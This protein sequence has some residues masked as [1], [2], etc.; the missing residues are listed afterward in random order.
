MHFLQAVATS[1][2][3][4]LI[5]GFVSQRVHVLV[6]SQSKRLSSLLEIYIRYKSL[7]KFKF[8]FLEMVEP[9]SKSG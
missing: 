4:Q 6:L 7:S 8:D 1:Q 5:S 9:A 2:L 3:K